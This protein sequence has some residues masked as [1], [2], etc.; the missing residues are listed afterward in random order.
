MSTVEINVFTEDS[1]KGREVSKKGSVGRLLEY[2]RRDKA[3]RVGARTGL[4]KTAV[5]ARL[6]RFLFCI[7]A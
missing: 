7:F 5:T 2:T 1:I 3:V 6:K 4:R